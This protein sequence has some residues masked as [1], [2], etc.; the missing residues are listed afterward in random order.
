M[1]QVYD[2]VVIGSGFG[3]AINGCRL[4]QA[5]RSV[6]ILERGKRWGRKDFPRTTGQVARAFWNY[7]DFGLLDYRAFNKIDVIQASGVGGGSLVYFNVHI[8]TPKEIFENPRWPKGVK[9]DVLDPYYDRAKEMLEA[10]P[11]TPPA[12]LE[13]PNRTKAFLDAS[14]K[15]GATG[16]LVNICVYTGPERI[17]SHGIRQDGC[18]YCGNC[19]LG[20]HVHAKHTLDLNYIALAE[21]NGA[22]VFPLHLVQYIEPIDPVDTNG[23]RVHF[24]HFDK[25]KNGEF[26]NGSVVGRRVI[27]S[28]GSLGS[29]E[30]LLRCRDTFKTLPNLGRMV[31][32]KFSGNGDFLLAGTFE[33][34]REI[35]PGCGPSITAGAD[36]STSKNRIYIEDLGFPDPFLWYLESGLPVPNRLKNL[37]MFI[38]KYFMRTVGLSPA[39]AFTDGADKLF[40]GGVTPRFL[41]Y[42]GMG[43]D[44]ADGRMKLSGENIDI[45][46]DSSRSRE[47]FDEMEKALKE[48]SR[49]IGGRYKT[50]ILWGWPFKKLLTAHPLGGCAMSD[51]P[52][53][54]VVNE[55][56]QVWN[57]PGLY[58]SDG[59]IIPTALSVNPSATISALSERIAEHIVAN[60]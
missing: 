30:I 43:T 54:G 44:A 23:Y 50:S 45:A 28:A 57:Y 8:R 2:V 13:L 12:E 52:S 9:R 27:V 46:W 34:D 18:V 41:P 7:K 17:N 40:Q 14:K 35:D 60:S 15:I 11:L 22:E 36:F 48:L 49:G 47:M 10:Q 29:T 1:K 26:E 6:C 25:D 4:A 42:L 55:F 16:E 21:K 33:C 56:G 58:V 20:C 59:S 39:S 53:E 5:G 32:E 37:G 19:M 38:R 31:G 51:D 24:K 3:G